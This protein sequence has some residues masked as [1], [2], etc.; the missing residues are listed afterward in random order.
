ML[1]TRDRV[2]GYHDHQE[3]WKLPKLL[4]RKGKWYHDDPNLPYKK[5]IYDIRHFLYYLDRRTMHNKYNKQVFNFTEPV[6][7]DN[8]VQ[9]YADV[10]GEDEDWFETKYAVLGKKFFKEHPHLPEQPF[11]LD[12]K[13]LVIIGVLLY[14]PKEEVLF[15]TTGCGGSGKS[16]F[17]NIIK[18]L[19]NNDFYA[20]TLS[21]L[22]DTHVF[23]SAVQKSIICGDEIGAKELNFDNLKTL[24]SKQPVNVN[25]K[26]ERPYTMRSQSALFWCCNKVPWMDITDSG[27]TRRLVYYNKNDKIKS[28]DITLKSKE[29]SEQE[30]T[31]IAAYAYKYLKDG[32]RNMFEDET[33]ELLSKVNSV[34]RFD[35][36]D[37][38][39]Y[40]EYVKMCRSEGLKPCGKPN[41]DDIKD[42]IKQHNKGRIADDEELPF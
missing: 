19:F 1:T 37:Q 9:M 20:C 2:Y 14:K 30:L 22:N 18:Q 6:Q 24:A 8:F 35:G 26:F 3:E 4:Y 42:L 5:H 33:W 27:L 13:Q 41:Y 31:I 21:D 11:Y 12:V 28:P 7:V 23:A 25:P 40:E 38:D 36:D 39:V 16:T 10:F 29:Y 32:W 17:L 15:I 34:C